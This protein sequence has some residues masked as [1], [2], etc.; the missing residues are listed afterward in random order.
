VF[1][2]L[3]TPVLTFEGGINRSYR[4]RLIWV[5]S[6]ATGQDKDFQAGFAAFGQALGNFIFYLKSTCHSKILIQF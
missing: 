3:G 4:Y 5:L 1:N 2:S 6:E